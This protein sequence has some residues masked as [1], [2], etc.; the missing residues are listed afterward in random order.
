[1]LSPP[2]QL[3]GLKCIGKYIE[4][5]TVRVLCDTLY[6]SD[7]KPSVFGVHSAIYCNEK[8]EFIFVDLK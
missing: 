1:M 8:M 4:Q 6:G 3:K 2:Y 7:D 5:K